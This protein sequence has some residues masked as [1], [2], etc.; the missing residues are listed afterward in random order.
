MSQLDLLLSVPKLA[1]LVKQ[2]TPASQPL[3]FSQLYRQGG[4]EE[5]DGDRVIFEKRLYDRKLAGAR[6]V[7]SEA[8]LK[9]MPNR[10]VVEQG[11]IHLTSKRILTPKQLYWGS[12]IGMQLRANAASHVVDAVEQIKGEIHRGVEYICTE[13]LQT[14]GG[15]SLT[16]ANTDFPAGATTISDTMTIDGALQTFG[17]GAGWN[18]ASTG[19]I[20]GTN[21]LTDAIR[22][23]E[24]NGHSPHHAIH[25]RQLAKALVKNT[26]VKEWLTTNGGLTVEYFKQAINA[27][28]RMQGDEDIAFTPSV[29]SGIGGL[30]S[31]LDWDHGYENNAGTFTRYMDSDKMVLLPRE[32]KRVLGFAEGYSFI[33]NNV[34]VFGN[35]EQGADLFRAERGMQVYAYRTIDDVGNIVVVGRYTFAPIIRD[36]FGVL[37]LTGLG[38]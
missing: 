16:P 23:M 4:V 31:W 7:E 27:A 17:V 32:L 14:A 13:L 33:P 30:P 21:Q 37:T 11:L 10:K 12:G 18:V 20:S 28:A 1:E 26:E 25:S 24:A 36:E 29:W 2:R 38:T 9:P 22:Q 15:V 6:T 35:A 19:I 8:F 3:P 5:C 34:Q